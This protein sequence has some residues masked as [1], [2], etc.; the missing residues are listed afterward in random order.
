MLVFRGLLTFKLQT[1]QFICPGLPFCLQ[2]TLSGKCLSV[3]RADGEVATT[4]TAGVIEDA[5][6]LLEL[7]A[8]KS[9]SLE[10]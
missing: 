9:N 2:G 4:G 3:K 7:D 10:S 5:E 8:F 6:T 1:T